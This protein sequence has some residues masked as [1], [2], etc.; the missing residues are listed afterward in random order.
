MYVFLKFLHDKILLKHDLKFCKD[1]PQF[2]LKK[3]QDKYS[4]NN[5][6]YCLHILS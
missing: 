1:A 3:R 6:I 2:S 5:L 4:Q